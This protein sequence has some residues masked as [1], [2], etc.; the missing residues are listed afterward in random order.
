LAAKSTY[1]QNSGT[2]LEVGA[3]VADDILKNLCDHQ[4]AVEKGC[5]PA[6]R[7]RVQAIVLE[8]G[9]DKL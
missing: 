8:I 2:H 1:E 9:L 3:I 6:H 4:G 7:T 5:R